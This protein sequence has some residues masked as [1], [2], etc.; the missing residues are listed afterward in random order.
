M[1][2]ASGEVALRLSDEIFFG[3]DAIFVFERGAWKN[4]S[5]GVFAAKL[6]SEGVSFRDGLSTGIRRYLQKGGGAE[7]RNLTAVALTS[8]FRKGNPSRGGLWAFS[9]LASMLSTTVLRKTRAQKL[10]VEAMQT[11]RER[12]IYPHR[13][14]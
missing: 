10:A 9:R 5:P 14:W 8:A 7:V 2:V 4:M 1:A 12:R 13:R 6:T 3:F 11:G